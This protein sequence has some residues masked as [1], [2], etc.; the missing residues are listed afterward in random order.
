MGIAST[1]F[2][3]GFVADDTMQ[4]WR[5][6]TD[7]HNKLVNS[8]RLRSSR[9]ANLRRLEQQQPALSDGSTAK[10][11]PDGAATPVGG[12]LALT[13]TKINGD[14][15]AAVGTKACDTVERGGLSCGEQ[16]EDSKADTET[17]RSKKCYMCKARYHHLH[18]FY[19]FARSQANACGLCADL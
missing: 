10:L 1:A 17:P 6:E 7:L 3:N 15:K 12:H 4:P 8:R 2:K 9:I 5:R 14:P 19:R 18:H 11:I 13:D 16:M